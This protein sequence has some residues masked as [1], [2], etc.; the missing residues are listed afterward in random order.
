M[1]S[2]ADTVIGFVRER[3]RLDEE[4][5]QAAMTDPLRDLLD[6]VDMIDLLT[7]LETTFNIVIADD[8]VSPESFESIASSIGFVEAKLAASA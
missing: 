1:T 5:V 7:L 6:S 4:M 3:A 2:V 8:E